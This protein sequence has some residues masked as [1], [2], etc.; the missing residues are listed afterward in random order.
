MTN[1]GQIISRLAQM[2]QSNSSC[3]HVDELVRTCV[4]C[5]SVFAYVCTVKAHDSGSE[6]TC[7]FIFGSNLNICIDG[8]LIVD[9]DCVKRR[10]F[11]FDRH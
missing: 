10:T 8:A 9:Y 3:A 6:N 7:A 5:V 1:R 11:I 4:E 2:L